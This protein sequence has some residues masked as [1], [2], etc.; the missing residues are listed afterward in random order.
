MEFPVRSSAHVFKYPDVDRG[1]AGVG[2]WIK[3]GQ[4]RVPI[5]HHME[6]T[7]IL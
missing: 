3:I 7:F 5:C 1:S 4:Q 6:V 2:N